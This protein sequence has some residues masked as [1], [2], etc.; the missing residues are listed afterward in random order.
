MAKQ[1]T[2]ITTI[3]IRKKTKTRLDNLKEYRRETYDEILEKIFEILNLSKVNPERARS[4]LLDLDRK[5]KKIDNKS[6]IK[7]MQ[8]KKDSQERISNTKDEEY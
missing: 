3:K 4:R 6:E 1:K 5:N 7:I 8:N 2:E